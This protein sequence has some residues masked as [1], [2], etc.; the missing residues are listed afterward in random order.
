PVE[1]PYE[2]GKGVLEG[3]RTERP[4]TQSV[5]QGSMFD[6]VPATMPAEAAALHLGSRKGTAV[7]TD[8]G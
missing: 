6:S 1:I 2:A 4:E 5:S 8:G 3:G 7:E